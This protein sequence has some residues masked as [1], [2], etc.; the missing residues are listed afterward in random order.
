MRDGCN[1][2]ISKCF[3]DGKPLIIDG[4]HVDPDCYLELSDPDPQTGKREYRI[5]TTLSEPACSGGQDNSALIAMQRK[6]QQIDQSNSLIIPF[7][8]TIDPVSHTQC[9]ENRL[10]M[11]FQ[12]NKDELPEDIDSFLEQKLNEYQVIQS[13]L[14]GA[15]QGLNFTELEIDINR[16]EATIDTMHDVILD[17]IEQGET[18]QT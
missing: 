7:L 11:L 6:M 12:K 2:D 4:S 5:K 13:Y 14:K 15:C 3:K 10:S 1:F 17:A 8:L 18:I 9:I 16:F